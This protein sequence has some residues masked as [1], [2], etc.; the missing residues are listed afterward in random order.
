QATKDFVRQTLAEAMR[1]QMIKQAALKEENPPPELLQFSKYV[2]QEQIPDWLK[3]DHA[4]QIYELL[5][6]PHALMAKLYLEAAHACRREIYGEISAPY[7]DEILLESLGKAIDR[8]N[9]YVRSDCLAMRRE[10]HDPVIDPTKPETDP[11]LLAQAVARILRVGDEAVTQRKFL[12]AG[13]ERIVFTNADM[14]VLHLLNAGVLD[15]LGKTD[16]A[17]K[18]L[19]M[20]MSYVPDRPAMPLEDKKLEARIVRQLQLLRG[21]VAE[22]QMCLKREHDYLR[23]AAH[24]YISAISF[25]ELKFKECKRFDPQEAAGKELE[26]APT[27]YLLG[28]LLRRAGEEDSAAAWFAAADR[29]IEKNL[30]LVEDAEKAAPHQD[31]QPPLVGGQDTELTP[32]ARERERLLILRFWDKEQQALL[33][34]TKEPSANMKSVIAQVLNA[35]GLPAVPDGTA[36]PAANESGQDARTTT[37]QEAQTPTATHPAPD[38]QPAASRK[39][40]EAA[41]GGTIKTRE[42]LYKLYYA[43]ILRYRKEHKEE[44]PASL[45]ELV[46]AGCMKAEDSNL[47][48]NGKLLCPETQE[49]LG[50]MRKWEPG[51][52]TAPV[53]YPLKLDSKVLY[54]DGEIREGLAGGKN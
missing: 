36:S 19:E 20:A 24:H 51:D 18:S 26:A 27:S 49:R 4:L 30:Q 15:R 7:L 23:K 39:E 42:Q 34:G 32:Y 48:E 6:P 12:Q 50:Y 2:K 53:L 25:N 33:K 21:V 16:E 45:Q 1:K 38:A 41:A 3:Y 35:V 8:I 43:A 5:K 11:R 10:R 31:V 29:I 14:F 52:K 37:G 9:R 46:K 22:R 28:E 47:D 54:A 44:N 40:P 17:G 13:N